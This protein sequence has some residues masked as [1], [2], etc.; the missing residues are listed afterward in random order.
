MYAWC[1]LGKHS[2]P[3]LAPQSSWFFISSGPKTYSR[4]LQGPITSSGEASSFLPCSCG[5]SYPVHPIAV[6]VCEGILRDVCPTILFRA[7]H[8]FLQQP[9]LPHESRYQTLPAAPANLAFPILLQCARLFMAGEFQLW[10]Y[11]WTICGAE[12]P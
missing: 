12:E 7:A 3:G 4:G 1:M 11:F 10:A 8:F 5:A 9:P 6:Q 2:T